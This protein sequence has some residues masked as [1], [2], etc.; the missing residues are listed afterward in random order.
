MKGVWS[1]L[2]VFL[3]MRGVYARSWQKK[4]SGAVGSISHEIYQYVGISPQHLAAFHFTLLFEN[5]TSF[6]WQKEGQS[7]TFH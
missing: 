2:P 1:S 4:R 6:H 3:Q 5:E 7:I